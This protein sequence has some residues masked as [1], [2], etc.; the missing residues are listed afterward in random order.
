MANH[1]W[2]FFEFASGQKPCSL[3]EEAAHTENIEV[4]ASHVGLGVNP[5]GLLALADRLAQ[6]PASW[7]R[8]DRPAALRW[9]MA[10]GP[11]RPA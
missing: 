2:R 4:F 9:S 11:A 6:D 8:F 7:R 10:Q 1:A 3:N 5:L